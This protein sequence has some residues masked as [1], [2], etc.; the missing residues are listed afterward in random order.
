LSYFY[1]FVLNLNQIKMN[2]FN[3]TAN[4]NVSEMLKEGVDYIIV[5]DGNGAETKIVNLANEKYCPRKGFIEIEAMRKSNKHENVK[6]I[7]KIRDKKT[8][9]FYGIPT[10]INSE[11]KELQFKAIWIDNK[12]LFDLSIPDQAMACAIILNSQYIEGSPNQQGRSLWKVIDKEVIAHKEINKRTLRRQ[13]EVIIESLSGSALEEAAI[14]LGINVDANRSVFMMTNEIYRVMELDPKKF[15]ELHNNPEREYISVFN[16]A[17]AKGFIVN[18]VLT[19]NYIYGNIPLGHNKEMAIK[20]L[21]D[22]TGMATTL[23]AKCDM[24]DAESRKSMEIKQESAQSQSKEAEMQK[25][26]ME[27]EAELAKNKKVEEF[28]DPF[29]SMESVVSEE[30]KKDSTEVMADLKARAKELGIKGFALPHMTEAKLVAAIEE[31]ESK[32]A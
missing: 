1:I 14:N 27:L 9:L 21:V 12:M 7:R 11:T 4:D 2:V 13:A 30:T 6:M 18:D 29:A 32:L 22:N 19:G 17:V 8:N 24:Q 26:I 23:N 25:K 3:L 10:G 28:K 5:K 15:I 20:F 16:K 31:A